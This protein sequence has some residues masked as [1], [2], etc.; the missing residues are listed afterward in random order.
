ML[1]GMGMQL[2]EE[3]DRLLAPVVRPCFAAL[4]LANDY[5]SFNKEWD[6]FQ[7]SGAD[8][9]IN[10]VWLYMQWHGVDVPTA[11]T[12]VRDATASYEQQF[13]EECEKYQQEHAPV[14]QKIKR[15]MRALHCEIS[16]NVV[17][18]INCPRY[19]PAFRSPG[20]CLGSCLKTGTTAAHEDLNTIDLNMSA[21][22]EGGKAVT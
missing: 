21:S 22:M 7:K 6:M 15:Y 8:T 17:W 19:H 14:S 16:G 13:L 4:G 5:F 2:T 10:L 18:S 1:F 12:M 11:K 3:E 9:L 20:E